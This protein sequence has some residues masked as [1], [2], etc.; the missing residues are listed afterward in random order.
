MNEWKHYSNVRRICFK[1]FIE[2]SFIFY[3]NLKAKIGSYGKIN[4]KCNVQYKKTNWQIKQ[5]NET[6]ITFQFT[7]ILLEIIFFNN[8]N[9]GIEK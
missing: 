8:K 7:I 9:I 4:F 5:V 2:D 6:K 1:H 3:L